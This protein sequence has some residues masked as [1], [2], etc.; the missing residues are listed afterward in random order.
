MP[1]RLLLAVF[2]FCLPA[3]SWAQTAWCPTGAE[4]QYGYADMN[5]SGTVTMRYAADTIVGGK[6]AQVLRRSATTAGYMIPGNPYPP[7]GGAH[8]WRLPTI[9]TRTNGDSVLFWFGGRYVP[10]YCFGAQ[11]G[12]SWTTYATYPTGVCGQY[13]VQIIVDSVGTQL[14][15]GQLVHWQAVHVASNSASASWGRRIYAGIGNVRNLQPAGG[16]CG[17]TDPGS[18]LNLRSFKAPGQP[19]LG[20]G[21]GGLTVLA[22]ATAQARQ[23]G[24]VAYP[25]PTTGLLTVQLPAG[26]PTASTLAL[27]DLTGRLLRQQP[28]PASGQLDLR[29]LPAG[30]YLLTLASPGQPLLSQQVVLQ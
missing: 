19:T 11:P 24:F 23:A 29:G 16:I 17:G 4:W 18:I 5:E 12:Q 13:P 25:M 7:I 30:V 3:L 21:G 27:H 10:L 26:L 22:T 9:I 20:S 1:L 28:V 8:T 2:L 6:T 14:L 15:G